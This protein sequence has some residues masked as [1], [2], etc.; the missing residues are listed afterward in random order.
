MSLNIYRSGIIPLVKDS[1]TCNT[2][3]VIELM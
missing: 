2:D 3:K 1:D